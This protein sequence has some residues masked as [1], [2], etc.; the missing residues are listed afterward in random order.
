MQVWRPLA[1]ATLTSSITHHDSDLDILKDSVA[2]SGRY[3]QRSAL[4][5]CIDF[6]FRYDMALSTAQLATSYILALTIPPIHHFIRKEGREYANAER[7]FPDIR[8][9]RERHVSQ[10]QLRE[11]HIKRR[12]SLDNARSL[13]GNSVARGQ[14]RSLSHRLDWH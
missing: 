1:L 7:L 4:S 13:A 2:A 12:N 5:I 6:E 3:N 9:T 8:R 14:H 10:V 11:R